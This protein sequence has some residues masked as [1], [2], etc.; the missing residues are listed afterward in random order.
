MKL[1][2]G[3]GIVIAILAFIGFIM[4]MVTTMITN[5]KYNHDLV[6]DSYYQKEL[7]YQDNINAEQNVLAIKDA[8]VI[9]LN[10]KGLELLF[11][12][13]FQSEFINGKVFL[14]RPSDKTLDSEFPIVLKNQKLHIPE[15]FLVGGRWNITVDFNYKGTPFLYHKEL[16]L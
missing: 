4:F 11:S 16:T 8:I 1:N 9:Q 12:E 7:K 15:K 13:E 6:T 2:W 14:Y 5:H 3:T 10:Q